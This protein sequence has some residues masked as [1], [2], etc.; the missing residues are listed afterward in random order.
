MRLGL[1][2]ATVR[3][4]SCFSQTEGRCDGLLTGSTARLPRLD[5]AR[6]LASAGGRSISFAGMNTLNH[7]MAGRSR[8]IRR[9]SQHAKNRLVGL[10]PFV[11]RAQPNYTDEWTAAFFSCQDGTRTQTSSRQLP[12]HPTYNLPASGW[13]GVLDEPGPERHPP[14]FRLIGRSWLLGLR[15]RWRTRSLSRQRDPTP[16]G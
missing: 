4:A 3:G 13:P 16:E 8:P 5:L 2:D 10:R 6:N 11:I 1:T 9:V 14:S 7:R 15:R 12:P